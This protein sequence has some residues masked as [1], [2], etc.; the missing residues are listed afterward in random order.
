MSYFTRWRLTKGDLPGHPFRGNQYMSAAE[1]GAGGGGGGAGLDPV[2]D[3][4][5]AAREQLADKFWASRV[6]DMVR[7]VTIPQRMQEAAPKVTIHDFKVHPDF[8]LK[9][10]ITFTRMPDG[11][12]FVGVYDKRAKK[13]RMGPA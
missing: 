9:G 7:A 10:K 4:H 11:V 8:P 2:R 5:A 6:A 3:I 12:K 13:F 1:A